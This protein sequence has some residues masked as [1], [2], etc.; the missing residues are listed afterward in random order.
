MTSVSWLSMSSQH[1]T[2][3]KAPLTTESTP[4]ISKLTTKED[5]VEPI[6]PLVS[7][8]C[9][10][11]LKCCVRWIGHLSATVNINL[12][13]LDDLSCLNSRS[14]FKKSRPPHKKTISLKAIT[15]TK[16][17]PILTIR[18]PEIRMRESLFVC[19]RYGDRLDGYKLRQL[20]SI[21]GKDYRAHCDYTLT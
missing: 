6:Y 18:V 15:T 3:T 10:D 17:E 20:I 13:Y 5:T 7:S 19:W 2:S 1:E 16:K 14:R 11:F 21:T 9:R 4:S 12:P 8:V